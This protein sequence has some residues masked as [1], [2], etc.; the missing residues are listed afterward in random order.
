[1][2]TDSEKA[3]RIAWYSRYCH[4]VE[5]MTLKYEEINRQ[6]ETISHKA[7]PEETEYYMKLAEKYKPKYENNRRTEY[8][9]K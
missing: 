7:T 1:M 3:R 9:W 2:I 4:E 6:A 8:S 5:K